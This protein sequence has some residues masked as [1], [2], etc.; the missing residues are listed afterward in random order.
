MDKFDKKS[1]AVP[2]ESGTLDLVTP[3]FD[4]FTFLLSMEISYKVDKLIQSPKK[5]L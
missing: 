1:E 3:K 2:F 5:S 4:S